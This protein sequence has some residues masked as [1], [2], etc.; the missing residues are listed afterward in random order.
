MNVFH[1]ESLEVFPSVISPEIAP[2]IPPRIP[3]MIPPRI[4][5]RIPSGI[6]P[7]ILLG[8]PPKISPGILH[9]ISPDIPPIGVMACLTSRVVIWGSLLLEYIQGLLKE[10]LL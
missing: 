9:G 3:P 10:S 1:E 5:S 8:I 6:P 2:M 7:E 4:H